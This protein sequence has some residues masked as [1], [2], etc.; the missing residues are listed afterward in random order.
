VPMND[1]ALRVDWAIESPAASRS[2]QV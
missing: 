2:T 1:G